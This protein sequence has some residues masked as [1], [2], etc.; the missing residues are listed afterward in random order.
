MQEDTHW[1]P[2]CRKSTIH[3]KRVKAQNKLT[4]RQMV[5]GRVTWFFSPIKQLAG[6]HE[7]GRG[8]ARAQ[9]WIRVAVEHSRSTYQVVIAVIPAISRR[10]DLP[11]TR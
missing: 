10:I 6:K 1:E 4:D 2:F 8:F 5:L 7:D 9:L 11:F 3:G